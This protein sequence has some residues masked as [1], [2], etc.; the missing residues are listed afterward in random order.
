MIRRNSRVRAFAP[1]PDADGRPCEVLE[2][3]GEE[4]L[5]S[6][7]LSTAAGETVVPASEIFIF[8]GAAPNDV[9][10]RP[11]LLADPKRSLLELARAHAGGTQCA[12]AATAFH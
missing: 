11:D 12:I 6:L 1:D 9:P 3:I 5:E 4:R 10:K 2:A 8:I 7:R